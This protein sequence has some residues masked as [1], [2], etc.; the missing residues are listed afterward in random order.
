MRSVVA[1][2]ICVALL[3]GCASY[4]S[5]RNARWQQAASAPTPSPTVNPSPSGKAPDRPP[6]PAS[7]GKW[8]PHGTIRSTG[9]S[10]VA[11]TF[12]DG[13]HPVW[14][15]RIL[16]SLR[17]AGVKATFCVIG[18]QARRYPN[19][20]RA[21]VRDGHAL[22]NHSWNHD[23]GLGSRSRTHITADLART[24][25]AIWAAVPAAPIRYYRQPGGKWTK[26]VVQ[27]ARELGMRSLHWSVDPQDWR[28]PPARQITGTVIKGTRKGG[29]VLLHDGGG[30]RSCTHRALYRILPNL[31]RRFRLAPL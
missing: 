12:D 27:V 16:A 8:G 25:S 7:R 4:S 17:E 20:I 10:V 3:T 2:A 18:A 13:P 5:D 19:L 6:R 11:L 1:M 26:R 30:D 9:T 21:I 29:I 14:T 22:C 24:N 15:P 23:F 28:K 31:T